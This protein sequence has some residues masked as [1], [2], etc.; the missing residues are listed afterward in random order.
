M[1]S[2]DVRRGFLQYFETRDHRRVASSPLVLPS[3]PTLLFANAGMNQFKDVFTG[4][5]T[6]DYRR[7][8]TAQKCMR[9]SGKHNDL[10]QVGRTPR[11][12]TF[13]EMLG[14]FSF[15]DYFKKD[16]IAFAWDLVAR[17]WSVPRERLWVTVFG[18][19]DAAPADEEAARLWQEVAGVE[20]ERIL[21]LG[22]KDNFW[23]MGDTGPCGPC[24][25]IHVDLGADLVSVAGPSTPA[26]DER[27]FMEIWNLV[28]MQFEQHADGA[29]TPLPAPSVDTG[30]GL[31]R[32]AA[33]L[34]DKRSNYDSDL[35]QPILRAAAERAGTAY[36]GDADAD[37]SLR[38]IA[39]HARAL[40]FLVADGVIPANDNRGYVA[41]RILR[42]A[43]RHGRKLGIREP[44]LHEITPVV[45]DSMGETYPELLA[46]REAILEVGRRE[47]RQFAETVSTGLGMLEESIGRVREAAPADRPVLP[48][49]E[50]FRLYDTF[51]LPLDLARDIADEQGFSLDEAGFEEEM[52]KQRARAQASWKGG[53]A[54][55]V[56]T[57]FAELGTRLGTRFE[58]YDRVRLDGARVT[59]LVRDGAPVERLLEGEEGDVVLDHSPFYAEAGGQVGDTGV[60][61][62]PA[63]RAKVTGT[64]RPVPGLVASA[65]RVEHGALAVGDRVTAEVDETRR[66]AIMRNHTATHLAHAALRDVVGTHVKQAGSLVAA[67]RMRFDFSHFAPVSEQAVR[68]VEDLVNEKILEG[69]EVETRSMGLDEALRSGAMAL[70]GEKYGDEVRVVRV[71]DF[72]LE[73]CG[74]T[75]VANSAEI[76]LFKLTQ[77][78]GIASGVRR[79]EAVTGHGSLERFREAHAIV[80]RLEEA[81]S[82]PRADLVE[83]IDRRLEQLRV[84]QRELDRERSRSVRERLLETA[85]KAQ[86]VAGVKVMAERA[87]GLSA[88]EAREVADNLRRKLGSGVVV[89]GR[90]QDDKASL[91]VAVTDDLTGRVPAGDM[92][93]ELARIV[94]GGGGGRKDLAEAGG[95]DPSRIG[96][97]LDAVADHVRRRMESTA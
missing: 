88:P 37:V 77:E 2:H 85:S 46:A 65:V 59:A 27:R 52:A 64:R 9:V 44:F 58:G 17:E 36:G 35:F 12:H 20:P 80:S 86:V 74:G 91:L 1:T 4:K 22:E 56:D 51:G 47:E 71:G 40:C 16:A 29:M 39:D 75:H 49:R 82:V 45:L 43:I 34:Q 7:A 33:V 83:E 6:R 41:R 69:I 66:A 26:T 57:A 32:I 79:I 97:A 70:F 96:E 21:R 63:A 38:V 81:L 18:G 61:V 89:L 62:T 93:R 95:K 11:H 42:R 72:S 14:N 8:T 31:E 90:V 3:D 25:E 10:E 24:T 5:D 92:V 54:A 48:G 19:S 67:D 73:L 30:M 50:L 53:G 13:F 76:G 68:D 60:L 84:A 15:G 28:F 87:D 23:R 78:R 55:A 94:G